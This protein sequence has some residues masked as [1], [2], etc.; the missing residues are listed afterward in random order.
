LLLNTAIAT[1]ST[2]LDRS[3][4]GNERFHQQGHEDYAFWLGILKR[5]GRCFGLN[6]ELIKYRIVSG[7]VSSRKLKS[8]L[9]VW[10][11][12]RQNEGLS[13]PYA[14]WCLANYGFRAIVKRMR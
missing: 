4:A 14:I 6:E 7:S 2:M 3:I 10:R 5:H 9:W 12:Y 11:I 8:V 13:L 1:S